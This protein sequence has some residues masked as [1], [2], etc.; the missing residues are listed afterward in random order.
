MTWRSVRGTL[1]VMNTTDIARLARKLGLPAN[2]DRDHQVAIW[3]A[4]EPP[5][6][7]RSGVERCRPGATS[8]AP[9]ARSRGKT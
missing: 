9:G 7:A 5:S 2:P 3:M 8:A 1:M 6:P 4:S